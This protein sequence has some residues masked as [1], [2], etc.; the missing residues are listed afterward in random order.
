[1]LPD[2]IEASSFTQSQNYV[3]LSIFVKLSDVSLNLE[4]HKKGHTIFFI[5]R[6]RTK[7]FLTIKGKMIG[8]FEFLFK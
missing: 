8:S 3:T 5:K 2:S 4:G 1:M 7:I 6:K